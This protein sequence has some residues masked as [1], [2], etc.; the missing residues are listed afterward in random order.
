MTE[1]EK[2]ELLKKTGLMLSQLSEYEQG[3]AIDMLIKGEYPSKKWLSENAN[4]FVGENI[5]Q[6]VEQMIP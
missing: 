6:I 5:R 3:Q 2:Q 4:F 1:Q